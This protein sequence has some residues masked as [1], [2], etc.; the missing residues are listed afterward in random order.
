MFFRV[1]LF[2][3]LLTYGFIPQ[4]RLYITKNLIGVL[5]FA[6]LFLG[7]MAMFSPSLFGHLN[8]WFLFGDAL[9]L[10]EGGILAIVLSAELSIRR[11][12]I[13]PRVWFKEHGL[14]SMQHRKLEY[15]F[16]NSK[17]LGTIIINQLLDVDKRIV[18][19]EPSVRL[20]TTLNKV[21]H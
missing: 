11:T 21:A 9:T 4:L 13:A 17:S 14:L 6:M 5:G 20:N 15:P 3:L 8:T 7:S 2:T 12:N 10:I 19:F 1:I 18:N 16:V